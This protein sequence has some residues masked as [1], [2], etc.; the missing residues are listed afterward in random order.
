M[1]ALAHVLPAAVGG[2]LLTLSAAFAQTSTGDAAAAQVPGSAWDAGPFAESPD[3]TPIAPTTAPSS[4]ADAAAPPPSTGKS[5]SPPSTGASESTPPSAKPA[6]AGQAGLS[7]GPLHDG[8]YLGLTNGFGDLAVWGDGPNGSASISGF[9][10]RVGISV[11]GSPIRGLAV[12]GV[13]EGDIAVGNTFSGGPIV[14]ATTQVG[15]APPSMQMP[16]K[17]NARSSSY[18]VG[19]LADWF[20]VPSGGWHVGAGVGAGGAAITDDAGKVIAGISVGGSVFGGY[21]WWLGG[22]WSFGISGIVTGTPTL[23][24][25]D[26]R[27]ND[28]GYKM[29]PLFVGAQ[30]VILYY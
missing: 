17:G 22:N 10:T 14:I 12:A 20:P 16:L 4:I 15:N 26:S 6:E 11:G 1:R 3:A 25:T 18:L 5:Q 9:A 27:G 21:Q 29:V 23:N 7:A 13:I 24:M 30:G 19:V 28:T 2:V 8:F